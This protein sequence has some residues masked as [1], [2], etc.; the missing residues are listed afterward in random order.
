MLY[1]SSQRVLPFRLAM[2]TLKIKREL[3]DDLAPDIYRPRKRKLKA[4]PKSEIKLEDIKFEIKPKLKAKKKKKRGSSDVE[5]IGYTAPGRRYKWRGRKVRKVARPGTVI[6]YTPGERRYTKGFKRSADEMF[7]DSDLLQ[8]LEN[9]DGEFAY[10]KR[11]RSVGPIAMDNHNP[12][13]SMKP[14]TPQ[15][16]LP[17]RGVKRE[18]DLV[19]TVQLMA[20]KK[21]KSCCQSSNLEDFMR[22]EPGTATL[23]PARSIKKARYRCGGATKCKL[24]IEDKKSI[25]GVD[26]IKVRDVKPITPNVGIQTI[27][28]K[29]KEESDTKPII[30]DAK[31]LISVYDIKKEA[32]NLPYLE[33]KKEPTVPMEVDVKP[34]IYPNYRKHPSQEVTL[35]VKTKGKR[36]SVSEPKSNVKVV[37]GQ[38][39]VALTKALEYVRYHPSIKYAPK[40]VIVPEVRYHPSI[41]I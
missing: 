24:K 13:P 17:T 2:T 26:E 41:K 35:T 27:D 20:P 25:M 29:M 1:A 19:P 36:S 38:R 5:F 39:T 31:P 21:R 16:V 11:S 7:A 30:P 14:I 40:R 34:V 32:A 12:T 4:E 28:I 18:G 10:G 9:N 3:L 37:N 23:L 22:A 15:I 33:V 8:Q 6:V